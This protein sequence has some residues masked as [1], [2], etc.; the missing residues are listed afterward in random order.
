M[1]RI[2]PAKKIIVLLVIA[3]MI[4]S[5]AAYS[6]H[7][8]GADLT[9]ECLGGNT[10]K[11]TVSFYRDCIGIA[12]PANPLVTINSSSCS[13]SLSVTCYP[14]AGTGM[15]VTPSCSSSVTTCNGGSFT[16]IQEWIY[17]GIVTLPSNCSDWIFGYSLCCRNAA[18]TTINNPSNNTFYIYAT[19][20]NLV[21]T[22][23]SSPTFSNK[24][25]PF[26]CR[27]QQFCFNH[28]AYDADGDSLVYQL[29][30][31]KQ[32]VSTNVSYHT[33]YSASNPLNSSP[34]TTFN[35]ATGDICLTPQSLEVTVM[36]VLVKE[37][38]N[39]VL[40]GTVERDL[41]LT[42]MNCANNLPSLTGIN[43]TNNFSM[44]LCANQM[45]CFNI[46]SNDVDNT[47]QLSVVW[48]YGIAGANFTSSAATHPT[49]TFCWTPG[50]TDVGNTYSFTAT[51]TDNACPYNG[52]QTYAYTINVTGIS[53]NAGPDQDIACSDLA[54]LTANASG[55]SGAYSYLWSNGSTMQSITVGAGTYWVTANDG[56]CSAT[57]TVVVN[58][59]FLPDADFTYSSPLC[60]NL[61]TYFFDQSSTPA[62]F[63]NSWQWFFGDGDTSTL[64][65][66]F[67]QYLV[68]GNYDVTL[69]VGNNL[70]CYDTITAQIQV[71]EGPIADFIWNP[72]CQNTSREFV[73][74]SA[75]NTTAYIWDFG[76]G[77][78][79]TLQNP[80]HTFTSTGLH[81]VTLIVSNIAGCLDTVSYDVMVNPPPVVSAGPDVA[82][83][84]GSTVN[85][86]ATGGQY[87]SWLPGGQSTNSISVTP[88]TTT[89]YVVSVVDTNSCIAFDTV[90]VVINPL[91]NVN[92]GADTSVCLG[93]SINLI[94]SGAQSYVWNPGGLT[95]QSISV[96]PAFATTYSVIGTDANGCTASDAVNVSVTSLPV[97][98]AGPDTTICNAQTI[99]L[100]AS[101]GG[102]TYQWSPGGMAG[103][104]INVSPAS[105]R[106]YTVTVTNAGGCTATDDITV[107]VLP[108]PVIGL[109]SQFLCAGVT[110][111]LNAA[112]PGSQYS[113]TT[114]ETTQTITVNSPGIYGVT[115][116]D[117]AGCSATSSCNI[118]YSSIATI[119]MASVSFCQGDSVTLDAGYP[120]MAYDWSPGGQTTQTIVVNAA[121]SYDVLVTDTAGCSGAINFT[122][123]VDPLPNVSFV[124]TPAC[125]GSAVGFTNTS[126]IAS[127]TITDWSWNFGDAGTSLLQHPSHL[128]AIAGNYGVSLTTTS[129]SG[130][131][132][133]ALLPITVDPLPVSDFSYSNNCMGNTVAFTDLSTVA[134]GNITGYSWNFG[135]GSSSTQQNP[136]HAYASPGNYTVSLTVTTAGGCT[137]SVNKTVPIHPKPAANFNAATVCKGMQ[138]IFNN[139]SS[140]S[141]GSITGIFWDFNDGTTSTQNSPSHV[142]A[143]AG[144][145]NVKLIVT[146]QFGCTDTIVKPVTI[147]T[148]PATDAGADQV[149]CAGS[150]V[151][152]TATGGIS[153]Q[154]NPGGS[155]SASIVVSPIS[156]TSYTVTATAANG[157]SVADAVTVTVNSIPNAQAGA[158]LSTCIGTAVT[159]NGTGGLSYSWSPGGLTTSSIVVNPTS[160]SD[161]ILT[162]TDGNGCQD[163]DTVRVTV[164]SLP[165]V[166]A[167]PDRNICEGSTAFLSAT[168]ASTYQWNPNGATTSSVFVTPATTTSYTVIG[169]SIYGCVS[170]DTITVVVRTVPVIGMLPTF[171]CPG[172][173]VTLDAGNPGST[174]SWSTGETTQAISVSDSGNYDVI[175][176]AANGCPAMAST[177]ITVGPD[178]SAPPV[179]Y[180][181]CAGQ[182]VLLDAG[183]PGCTYLW[184]TGA[185]TQTISTG[186]AGTYFVSLTA[187]NGCGIT[188]QH[189]VTVNQLPSVT[190]SASPVCF[191]NQTNFA[192]ASNPGS[193]TVQSNIWDFGDSFTSSS[194]AATHAYAA[195][196]NYTVT[197]SLTSTAGCTASNSATAV[198]NPLPDADF[199]TSATCQNT[200][201]SFTNTS[202]ISSGTIASWSWN[203]GDG[204][205]ASNFAPQH[206]YGSSGTFNATLIATSNMGCK[207]TAN[208]SVTV[209]G[210]PDA[211]FSVTNACVFST[212]GIT[213]TS[214]SPG[215]AITAFDWD[216]GNGISSTATQPAITYNAAGNYTIRL[217]VTNAN[218]CMDTAINQAIIHPQP[219]ADFVFTDGCANTSVPFTNTSTLSTGTLGSYY[220]TFGDNTSS[221][222][223]NP[224]HGYQTAGNYSVTLIA[225]S[226]LGCSDTSSQTITIYPRPLPSFTTQSVCLG[227]DATFQ[228]TSTVP[229]GSITAWSWDFADG[230]VSSQSAPTH[231]YFYPG[232]YAVQL[233]ATTDH[234]CQAT[235]ISTV[236]IYPN[237]SAAFSTAG[238]CYGATTQF[239]NQ[240]TISGGGQYSS[241]WSFGDG[242]TSTTQSPSHLFSS[243]G[244][245]NVTLNIVSAQ[246]CST[247]VSNVTQVYTLPSARFVAPDACAGAPITFTNQSTS[248]DGIIANLWTFGDGT[249]SIEKN[250]VHIFADSGQYNVE[251]L[252]I[253]TNGCM[254]RYNDSIV[255]YARPTVSIAMNNGCVG[256]PVQFN[257]SSNQGS[258][259]NYIWT[260]GNS[261]NSNSAGFSHTFA[262][263]GSFNVTLQATS[264]LGCSGVATSQLHVYPNPVPAFSSS[265]VCQSSP[266]TFTNTS[267]L[268]GGSISNYTWSFGDGQ[269]SNLF[270]PPHTY[271][272]AGTYNAI[273]TTTSN[274]G[275]TAQVMR[276]VRVHPNPVVS[277][278]AGMQG[279]APVNAAFIP[280]VTISSGTIAGWLWNFSDGEVSTDPQPT[281][282]FNH[283][284]NFDVALTV[285]SDYGCQSS[286]SQSGVVRVF[287]QPTADFTADPM[288]TDIQMPIVHFQNQSQNY[289]A[290]QW[291]FGDGTS[292]STELNPTHTFGDTGTYSAMLI[293]VN[294]F[295]C[296]DTIM[297]RIEVKL[298]STLFIANC[299]TPNNDGKN[300]VFRP[301]HTNMQEIEVWIFDRWGKLLTSWYGLEG[302]W[303]GTYQG[304]KC[305]QDTYVY[306]IRGTGLDGVKSEWVGHVSI[307]Y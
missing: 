183:N 284:G 253:T 7:T 93:S 68:Y 83:C 266:T 189:S 211:T 56:T 2:L 239:I 101:G 288:I 52:S 142:F 66:P 46:F 126:T 233:T 63:I 157:C 192:F 130:C 193:G 134:T 267:S 105:T 228:N 297:R 263:A 65:N 82:V 11:I 3:R 168:G 71:E 172:S 217:I 122:T 187:P 259:I 292:T 118:T 25:V 262:T 37:Y 74:Y 155:T 230:T 31:P 64:Q 302:S 89:D 17:D 249:T 171:V 115:V 257:A 98:N 300:D 163:K 19:L 34:A 127:G 8:M 164:R 289:Q 152:L 251:L 128:Y 218:G 146:S 30:T 247:S 242:S 107:T 174:Y 261:I 41:Q 24:P 48:N 305:Q 78:T 14:R 143:L 147:N 5:G 212:L 248:Q 179:N 238:V 49:G 117:P 99:M 76:D 149:I 175:V 294:N 205:S 123:I 69:V 178:M 103:A 272:S 170:S 51:V 167:G 243:P 298:H 229:A 191:G 33:P 304:S 137:H 219:A 125:Y 244:N 27:G 1:K 100:T 124:H 177:N 32:T 182:S 255:S 176:I 273:L 207:D 44:T 151:T 232:T 162:V 133:S 185:T 43:G 240:S 104:S 160:T 87:Y 136:I 278:H 282:S 200:N 268:P 113:W 166:T 153:Y 13:K 225:T 264:S 159:L 18:I 70:G 220:W 307:V 221:A 55:G 110:T 112:N 28:G 15:E 285:V 10:Y 62:G 139:T 236:N 38:R 53:V 12:A 258:S 95:T 206:M 224:S 36:A 250:P 80:F 201:L 296:R 188:H 227:N 216:M 108:L 271:A 40:I 140:I 274:H 291:H 260:V 54:T 241:V 60:S 26:L 226:T 286:Y 210:I 81:T 77:S 21:S 231:N 67:H 222:G 119:T 141:T 57:D 22:C 145:Y 303:D 269:Q 94:A 138:T 277:F 97:V 169:T 50:P 6:S 106:T 245:F 58:M 156:T 102:A 223:G 287:P 47:Q 20:N 111:V 265:E 275:C 90:R 276:Q 29:I 283:P 301:Y 281:H 92:A 61:I 252:S 109:Q 91:P 196:G 295:G 213:N 186:T 132:A 214:S 150:S 148:L 154:W 197:V 215:S 180:Q 59:P 181:V 120:G 246:G 116:T 9:Y 73:N 161:Y 208:H 280:N 306:K 85:L 194:P 72:A 131:S 204:T 209:L 199:N 114:G 279:C 256:S 16:G 190:I 35:T 202:A 45:T 165:I 23:N 254:G 84:I 39:G 184:S 203:F 270:N 293:T 42:V 173:S 198:V 129:S 299:F 79:S 135:D 235:S 121:G 290:Y 158:N 237:P 96:N 86:T 4:F 144:T 195:A 88:A 75:G 234:G